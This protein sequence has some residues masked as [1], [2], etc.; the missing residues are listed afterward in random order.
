MTHKRKTGH[1]TWRTRKR[2]K[3]ERTAEW[4]IPLLL[5]DSSPEKSRDF[6]P[7]RDLKPKPRGL[8][9]E[10]GLAGAAPNPR[11]GPTKHLDP[12]PTPA[13][14]ENGPLGCLGTSGARPDPE[15]SGSEGVGPKIKKS[16]AKAKA[17]ARWAVV[18]PK[19]GR[20]RC[21]GLHCLLEVLAPDCQ[22]VQS[23]EVR[24]ERHSAFAALG[25]ER[26][27]GR[28]QMGLPLAIL[29]SQ[30]GR[31]VAAPAWERKDSPSIPLLSFRTGKGEWVSGFR[32][33]QRE[34]RALTEGSRK[35]G[36]GAK[37]WEVQVVSSR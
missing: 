31:G 10:G 32:W 29:I 9:D 28:G 36:S 27:W 5:T 3:S 1:P 37:G 25:G 16:A 30:W 11:P 34:A 14:T 19:P 24:G 17:G 4:G 20:G 23:R 33:P 2:T 12:W 7:S 13:V 18:V 8:S 22:S 6:S 15:A 26:L 21:D 35:S